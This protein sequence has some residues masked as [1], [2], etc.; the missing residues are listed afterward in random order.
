M[1]F[2][3]GEHYPHPRRGPGRHRY[4][5]SEAA[6]RA[7]RRNLSRSRLRS[8]RETAVIKL[9][10][11][12]A[13]FA[14]GP[15]VSQRALAGQLGVWPSYVCKIQKQSARGLDALASGQRGTL[16][17]LENA[18]RFTAKIRE[19]E[20]GLLRPTKFSHSPTPAPSRAGPPSSY[21]PNA[22]GWNCPCSACEAKAVIEAALERAA[23]QGGS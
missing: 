22:H 14:R 18:R 10:I 9:L 15:R 6:R 23:K 20:P 13:S 5:V 1:R 16:D 17:D 8:D 12:Q 7:R 21:A 19:R 4:H 11:W 3:K 2:Q